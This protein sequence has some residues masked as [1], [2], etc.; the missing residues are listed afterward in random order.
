MYHFLLV[1]MNL[2]IADI[3]LALCGPVCTAVV[4]ILLLSQVITEEDFMDSDIFSKFQHPL[5][6]TSVGFQNVLKTDQ[7]NCFTFVI[8][9]NKLIFSPGWCYVGLE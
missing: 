8:V 9:M 6:A 1:Q 5:E 4:T 3:L 7:A 2:C